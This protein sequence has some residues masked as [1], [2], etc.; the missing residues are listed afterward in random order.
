M[1]YRVQVKVNDAI[2]G[3]AR[4][5]RSMGVLVKL[6]DAANEDI[7]EIAPRDFADLLGMIHENLER[8]D[9]LV[10]ELTGGNNAR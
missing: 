9:K 3:Y 1:T 6:L 5:T 7:V 4:V 2:N 8:Q 10:A